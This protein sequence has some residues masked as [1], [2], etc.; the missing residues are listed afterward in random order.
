MS[1]STNTID[2]L[3]GNFK[4]VYTSAGLNKIIPSSVKILPEIE[5]IPSEKMG[6]L[7]YNVPVVLANE[8]GVTYGGDEGSAFTLDAPVAGTIKEA[9][10]K[11][12]E[13]VLRSFLSYGAAS[14]AEKSEGAFVRST[15]HLVENM[16]ESITKKLEAEILYGQMGLAEVASVSGNTFTIT[17]AEFASG[18]WTGAEN[19]RLDFYNGT[20]KRGS[21]SVVSVDL[22]ART[23]TVD[24][25]PSGVAAGDD[26]YEKG[27]YG[28][29]FAGIHKILSNSG[30]LFGIDASTY[31]LW[32]STSFAV[33]GNLSYEKINQGIAKAAGK[34]LDEDIRLY[35][36]PATWS[37]LA[38]DLA[39]FREYDSSYKSDG[40]E[41]GFRSVK[42]FS[43]NGSVEVI[44]HTYI[45][46]GYAFGLV[47][48]EFEK[49]GSTDVTFK[50]PGKGEDFFRPLENAAG[51]ELRCY[52]DWAIFCHK[53]NKQILYT[54]IT[55]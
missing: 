33:G 21:A 39:A 15:K 47:L 24:V 46:E 35:V 43:Q 44:P 50:V 37:K 51:F 55:N 40:A 31:N 32:K 26:V 4:K 45:K 3:N 28:K 52:A 20:T 36:S 17:T 22:D 13:I 8:H 29:E 38:T 6:G 7:N 48:D 5:F 34:G 27:A 41:Q 14:R 53:P 9:T 42:F 10:V 1:Q 2:T 25:M 30:A 54:G 11:G 18:L 49:V 16:V 23:V 19:M 12:N